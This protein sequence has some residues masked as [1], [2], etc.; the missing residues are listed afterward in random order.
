[1]LLRHANKF[2]IIYAKHVANE[3]FQRFSVGHDLGYYFLS[4]YFDHVLTDKVP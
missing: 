1:M 3:G 4:G 2:V